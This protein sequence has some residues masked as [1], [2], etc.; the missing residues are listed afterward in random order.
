MKEKLK[1]LLREKEYLSEITEDI[2]EGSFK[3]IFKLRNNYEI[4]LVITFDDFFPAR[5]PK[6]RIDDT[7]LHIPN[8]PHILK[9]GTICYLDQEGIIWNNNP[10]IALDLVFER[11]EN[12]L[13]DNNELVEYHREFNYYFATLNKLEYAVSLYASGSDIEEITV[14]TK[15]DHPFAFLK[16]DQESIKTLENLLER[17]I[18]GQLHY[19]ALFIPLDEPYNGPVPQQNEFWSAKEIESL[20]KNHVTPEKLKKVEAFSINKKNYYYL[21]EIPLL[22]GKKVTIGLWYKKVQ[23]YSKRSNPI[24]QSDLQ[25][26]FEIYP[27]YIYRYDDCSLIERGG[28][29]K[30]GCNVL[31]VGCGS[32]G[33]DILFLLA[34]SGLKNFTIVDYDKLDI[35]N[36]Y[37][38]FLGMN[39]AIENKKKVMLLKE[40]I[41]KR[42]PSIRIQAYDKDIL[43]LIKDEIINLRDY[44]L[45]IFA[46]GDPNIERWLNKL[47]LETETPAI[48]TWVEAYGLGG[49]AL[50]V[51]N[52]DR[53]CY[54][55]LIDEKLNNYASFAGRSDKPYTKNINGCS[56]TFTPYGGLD[57]MET[58]LLAS[59]LALR[60]INNQVIGNPLVSW[61]GNSKEFEANGYETSPRYEQSLDYL[62][63]DSFDYINFDCKYCYKG[64]NEDDN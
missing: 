52:G 35:V 5:L 38:H 51:N 62:Q 53:G 26:K 21:L 4:P 48:F 58:A 24:I 63:R 12:V 17:K 59:R 10:S 41:Q 42:Y 44:D 27:I 43:L 14:F 37:R 6:I 40:E 61:K 23:S 25:E 22:T 20:I 57:S 2:E 49:H 13:L 50:L 47:V 54:E 31:I 60:V 55:C 46:I 30:S 64:R 11:V 45:A 18:T 36:S 29:I 8:K 56:G 7:R 28:G 32:V 15:R 3:L 34:R 33:S 1:E 16:S 9:N 19:K 39:K